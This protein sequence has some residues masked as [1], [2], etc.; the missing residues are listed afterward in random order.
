MSG[1]ST[2]QRYKDRTPT[3]FDSNIKLTGGLSCQNEWLSGFSARFERSG[4]R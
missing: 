4:G 2:L 1:P 3:P